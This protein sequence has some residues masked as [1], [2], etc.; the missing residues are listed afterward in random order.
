MT[1]IGKK[2]LVTGAGGFI[3]SHLCEAML[4]AGAEVTAMIRYNSQNS[5]G[6]LE[7]LSPQHRAA[8]NVVAGTSKIAILLRVKLRTISG[9]S[10]SCANSNSL[11]LYRSS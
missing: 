9:F 7:F 5:W 2:V 3:A 1:W 8:L 4:E 10:P 11:L 6:N